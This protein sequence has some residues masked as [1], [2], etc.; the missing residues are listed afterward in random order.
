MD[1]ASAANALHTRMQPS[2]RDNNENK[3]ENEQIGLLIRQERAPFGLVGLH[4]A[5]RPRW[6]RLLSASIRASDHKESKSISMSR[7]SARV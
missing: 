6:R 3:A 7:R 2:S 5:Q 4:V 1:I